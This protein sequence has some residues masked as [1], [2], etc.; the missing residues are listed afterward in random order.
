MGTG[1]VRFDSASFL[2]NPKAQLTSKGKSF[3]ARAVRWKGD[4]GLFIPA[5]FTFDVHFAKTVVNLGT[6]LRQFMT[7]QEIDNG[8]LNVLYDTPVAS[9]VRR[10]DVPPGSFQHRN[11]I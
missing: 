4:G 10:G 7:L 5:R 11:R 6:F 3:S 8:N 9:A 1:L 2:E